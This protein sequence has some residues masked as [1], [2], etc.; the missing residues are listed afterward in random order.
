MSDSALHILLTDPH[1]GGGGQ[2]RYLGNLA[3]RLTQWGHRVTIACR[4][5]SVLE[6]RAREA[7]ATVLPVMRFRSGLRLRA[8]AHDVFALRRYLL[9]ER[10]DIIHVNGSQDHWAA[11]LARLLA[12]SRTPIVRTRHNTYSVDD[13]LANRW[14]NR[15]ATDFQIVVCETVRHDLSSHDAFDPERMTSIHNGVDPDEYAPDHAERKE[16]RDEFGYSDQDF[17]FGIAARLAKAKGHE[18]LLRAAAM[19]KDKYPRMKLLSLGNGPLEAKLQDLCREL[20]IEGRVTWAGFRNDVAR[21][22]QAF[23]AGVLPSI[24]CDTSSFSLKEEMAC[25][26]PV[27]ASDY[28]GLI[29]IV[30]DGVEGLIVP[31]GTVEPLAEAM[32]R[33]MDDP[34]SAI[35]MGK[36]G[37][38]RVCAEFSLEQFAGRTLEVYRQVI[39]DAAGRRSSA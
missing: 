24:D 35:A 22:T 28:G 7:G 3:Q 30:E 27:I 31:A 39:A 15:H 21:C 29:E 23:D 1:S 19:L 4:A 25:E 37:R 9:D 2:V 13:H 10:P 14:L 6:T 34:E 12:F 20:G 26:K 18:Y 17:V 36:A 8:W 38:E 5:G 33:L 16:A 32:A 11:V